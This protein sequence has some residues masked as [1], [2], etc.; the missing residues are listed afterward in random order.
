[1]SSW[2][3]TSLSVALGG[4]LTI[5]S[6]WLADSRLLNRDRERRN[7]DR[8]ERLTD[9]RNELQ[10]ETLL[11]LQVAS[12]NLLR[13]GGACLHADILASRKSGKWVKHQLPDGLSDD[14]LRL[15][16][17]V[18]LLST[19]VIDNEIR[20]LADQLRTDVVEAEF[21]T[22]E[23]DGMAS[24]NKASETQHRLLDRIGVK[25]REMESVIL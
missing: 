21:A 6:S 16:T 24:M 25:I 18:M 1:M 3:E 4:A 8:T 17:E 7:A 5:A 12:Q 2:I 20:L 11:A 9:R 22:S 13:N 14:G 23:S 10:R 19:R 15:N